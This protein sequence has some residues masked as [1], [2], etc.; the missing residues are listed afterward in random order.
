MPNLVLFEASRLSFYLLFDLNEM[1]HFISQIQ[2]LCMIIYSGTFLT[3]LRILSRDRKY[4]FII[5]K[6]FRI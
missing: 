2:E 3:C 4:Y 6:C 5:I 1:C